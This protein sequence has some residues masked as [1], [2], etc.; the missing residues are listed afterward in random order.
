MSDVQDSY[1]GHDVETLADQ[2]AKVRHTG[3]TNMMD[4]RGVQEVAHHYGL[5][6]LGE[7]I[8]KADEDEYTEVLYYMGD[9]Y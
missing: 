4:R 8:A 3:A 5:D 6:A 2:F 7:F 1:Y 9:E